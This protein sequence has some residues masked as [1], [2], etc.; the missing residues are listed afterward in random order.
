MQRNTIVE[1]LIKFTVPNI[2]E[3]LCSRLKK[4]FAKN[5]FDKLY[6]AEKNRRGSFGLP[7]NFAGIKHFGEV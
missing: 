7:S 6:S 3:G 5:G 4:I 2:L 1:T